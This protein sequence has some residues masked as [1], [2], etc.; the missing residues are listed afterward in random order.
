M[1]ITN[2]VLEN[3][4]GVFAGGIGLGQPYAHGS[5]NYNVRIGND[6]IIGNGGLTTLRR[7]RASSTAR[8]TTRSPTASSARTSAWSTAP[9]SRTSGLSPNGSIH[10]NQIYYN[11]PSTPGAGIADRERAAGPASADPAATGSGSGQRRPQ[12]DPEQLLSA[13][14]TAAASSCSTPSTQPINIRNNMIVNNVAA[15][16]GGAIML[17]DASN[18]RDRQQHVANN[19]TTGSSENSAIGVPH[20]AGLARRG[21]RAA[22]RPTALRCP[23]PERGHPARLLQ[24]GGA[25]Q[26]HLLE[27]RRLDARPVRTRGA[28]LV[29]QGF[30]D[31]EVHGTT[32]NADT[33]TPRFSDLTNGQILGPNG[34]LARRARRPGQRQR[35]PAVRHAVHQRAHRRRLAARPAAGS[36]DDHR[37]PTRRSG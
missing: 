13:L 25:V 37:R 4:G 27:Q 34:V 1:Q 21:E 26:Q 23:V 32:N 14:T 9:A 33:F 24:P 20:A 17:D 30:I 11:E 16:L 8:T 10:D 3:N 19:V 7:H 35:R 31:F 36:G 18:V 5:H 29:D 2:N 22:G 12:P 28:T 15:D 6:R